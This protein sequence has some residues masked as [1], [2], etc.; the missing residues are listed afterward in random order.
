[1]Q[2]KHHQE[3]NTEVFILDGSLSQADTKIA[4]E[5]IAPFISD[6]SILKI[7]IDFESVPFMDSSGIGV[8][9]SFHNQMKE[10]ERTLSF[11]NLGEN[12]ME[13]MSTTRLDSVFNIFPTKDAAISGMN[14]A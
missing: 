1:M 4:K 6:K 5:Y 14:A 11:C 10:E 8:L 13:I 3:Q 7:L 2:I 12:L 9:V